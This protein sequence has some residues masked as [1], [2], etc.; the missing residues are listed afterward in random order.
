MAKKIYMI[1]G[2]PMTL[3]DL[4]ALTGLKESTVRGRLHAGYRTMR[5]L[6]QDPKETAKLRTAGF[7]R[8]FHYGNG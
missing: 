4:V 5:K 1:D 7:R 8:S 6:A 3:D 2:E